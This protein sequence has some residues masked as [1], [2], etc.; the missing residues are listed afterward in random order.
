MNQPTVFVPLL[1]L[2]FFAVMWIGVNRLLAQLSGWR[3]LARHFRGTPADVVESVSMG[4]ARMGS[5]FFPTAY[6]GILNVSASRE[7]VGLSLFPLFAIGAPPLLIPWDAVGECRTWTLFGFPRFQFN[8]GRVQ[9]TL[10]G[11]AA[12]MMREQFVR[13][14]PEGALLASAPWER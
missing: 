6:S 8:V 7:G 5:A 1:F 14:N 10:V 9:V 3:W 12:R 11:R 4:S 2:V 13:L